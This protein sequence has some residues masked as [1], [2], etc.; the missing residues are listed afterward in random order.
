MSLGSN[1]YTEGS[2]ELNCLRISVE[3]AASTVTRTG[4][5]GE[6]VM[7]R[8]STRK[9]WSFALGH[10]RCRSTEYFTARRKSYAVRGLSFVTD[11][12]LS[13][14]HCL[15]RP[16]RGDRAQNVTDGWSFERGEPATIKSLRSAAPSDTFRHELDR[17]RCRELHRGPCADANGGVGERSSAGGVVGLLGGRF[18]EALQGNTLMFFS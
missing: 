12:T 3:S 18:G 16:I 13:G 2:F 7:R 6:H 1:G 10:N 8:L 11:A 9:K 17:D 4:S 14:V 5:V 15:A